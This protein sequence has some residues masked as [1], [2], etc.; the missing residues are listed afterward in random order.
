VAQEVN[1][2]RSATGIIKNGRVCGSDVVGDMKAG[3]VMNA[4]VLAALQ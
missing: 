2:G 1:G 3:L 4:F